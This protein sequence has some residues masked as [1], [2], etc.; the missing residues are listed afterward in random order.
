MKSK[1]A[2]TPRRRA[3]LVAAYVLLLLSPLPLL[4]LADKPGSDSFGTI[5]AACFGYVGFAALVL[6]ATIPN[7]VPHLAAPFGLDLLL[8]FHR[9]MG[10]LA[11]AIVLGHVAVLLLDDPARLPLLQLW[12]A[13]WRA[14]AGV[15]STAALLCLAA[16]SLW[17]RRLRLSYERW[18]LVHVALSSVVLLGAFVHLQLVA[19]YAAD[20]WLRAWSVTMIGAGVLSIFY[21]RYAR[22]FRATGRPYRVER[23]MAEQGD[24]TTLE[25]RAEGH[26]GAP[27]RPGQFA[28]LKHAGQPYSMV[29]HPFSYA[30][31]ALAPGT[32]HFTIKR[33]GD[34]TAA[35]RGIRA[36]S[37]LI[38]DGPHGS[39]VPALP[40]AGFILIV[41]GV[42][43]TPAMSILRTAR[44]ARDRRPFVLLYG[45]RNLDDVI[46]RDELAEL[47][48]ELDLQVVHVLSEPGDD[49]DGERGYIDAGLLA[50]RLPADAARRN[51]FV[52]GPGPMVPAVSM[53]LAEVGVP[54]EH[55]HV[56]RFASV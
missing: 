48:G 5:F 38:V 27:F 34:F 6:Q 2:Q 4:V 22:P 11:V 20:P 47:E 16:S 12:D 50:S 1:P 42:G 3:V 46:F 40:G 28:W 13:P 32:P 36:G 23:V 52:C 18:R 45:S 51:V 53:A 31:S 49:W 44:D 55:V 24:A 17:R 8:R 10:M 9:Q 41:G 33:L 56:E 54:P 30:S 25:L 26:P 19:L 7:R 21:V 15:L 14:R 29:E 43:I 39:Y 35:V 37:L